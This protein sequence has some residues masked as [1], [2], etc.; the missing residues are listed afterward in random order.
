MTVTD[1]W[2]VRDHKQRAV[3]QLNLDGHPAH[4]PSGQRVEL[5]RR[6]LVKG[7]D[8]LTR[9]WRDQADHPF[10]R[11]EV[12][13][14]LTEADLAGCTDDPLVLTLYREMCFAIATGSW[15]SGPRLLSPAPEVAER[16]PS[17]LAPQIA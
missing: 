8:Y 5:L 6:G 3:L 10:I 15:R 11:R 1:I 2:W 9:E 14:G 7:M 13:P 4:I 16:P 12:E 17:S